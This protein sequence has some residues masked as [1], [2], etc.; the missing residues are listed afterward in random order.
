MIVPIRLRT[1]TKIALWENLGWGKSVILS[2][3]NFNADGAS[4]YP[5][6]LEKVEQ[7]F[8][9]SPPSL[10][11]FFNAIDGSYAIY[12]REILYNPLTNFN[13]GMGLV[14]Q[15]RLPGYGAQPSESQFSLEDIST[16]LAANDLSEIPDDVPAEH[17]A[18]AKFYIFLKHCLSRF[19]FAQITVNRDGAGTPFRDREGRIQ[20]ALNLYVDLQQPIGV[21]YD[22]TPAECV[23]ISFG[24]NYSKW[25]MILLTVQLIT[26]SQHTKACQEGP[27]QWLVP[28]KRNEKDNTPEEQREE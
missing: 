21:C 4:V 5:I 10:E 2:T 9:G 6:S 13:Q 16:V 28:G 20:W 8:A 12:L 11:H 1:K 17:Q 27:V 23:R 25:D 3:R 22:G 15:R 26:Q 18:T 24:P 14:I 19:N 7:L